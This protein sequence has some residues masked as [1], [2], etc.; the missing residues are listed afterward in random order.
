MSSSGDNAQQPSLRLSGIGVAPGIAVAPAVL[1]RA[2]DLPVP[3]R[4]IPPGGEDAEWARLT[5]ARDATRVQLTALRD[6]LAGESSGDEAGIIDSHLMV[7]DDEVLIEDLHDEVYDR[8]HNAEWGVRDVANAYIEKLGSF[9]DAL[10]SE[11]ADDISDVSRR[12]LRNL[13][14]IRDELP[15]ACSGRCVLVANRLT[16]SEASSLPR[17]V[18][19]GVAL[20]RGSLT[21]H[22]ALVLRACGIPAVFGLGDASSRVSP[23]QTIAID[24]SRGTVVIQPGAEE[25]AELRELAE[26][27]DDILATYGALRDEPAVTPDG[28]RVTLFANISSP[29]DVASLPANGAEGVGLFRTEYL[30]LSGG[31]PIAEAE[32]QAAYARVYREMAGRPVVIRAFDLGG[33]KFLSVVG[34]H[35]GESN[36]FLG[37]RS[38]RFLLRN[39]E[40]FR[41][42]I[43]AILRA[44]AETGS[45]PAIM[46]PMVAQL[47][48]LLRSREILDEC[49]AEVS[50][51]GASFAAPPRLGTM[52][53]VPSAALQ[54]QLLA[55]NCDFFSIGSNDLAQYTMAADRGNELVSY[56]YQPAHPA[57]LRLIHMSAQAARAIGINISLCGDM[58]ARP[59]LALLLLGMRLTALSMPATAIPPIKSLIRRVP[60]AEA[61][62]LAVRAMQS[63]T[64][65][66]VLSMSRELIARRAPEIL[67]LY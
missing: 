32:Q 38:I 56:L 14:G 25:L 59:P 40:V 52:I 20:D 61:E 37:L 57:V 62:Q 33:D 45:V 34:E 55:R 12:L 21:S 67:K 9:N 43:R 41:A 64:A 60:V 17:G 54:A 50:A 22:A 48:E 51:E 63:A 3:R 31:R 49:V 27:R 58:A 29:D 35:H 42:Q 24:G 19:C 47:P 10:L 26:T 39:E 15:D 7:L 53:E 28:H 16:P 23:G 30:W 5:A 8:H 13:L 66:E 46:L 65:E 1:F 18:V 2:R 6:K 44:A 11:R 36:P 4:Q